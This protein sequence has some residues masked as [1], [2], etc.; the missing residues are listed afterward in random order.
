[1]A[2][3]LDSVARLE[4]WPA[5][6]IEKAGPQL[7]AQYRGQILPLVNLRGALE[8]RQGRRRS[9]GEDV[10]LVPG[11]PRQV[12]VCK[13]NGQLVGLLVERILDIVEDAAEL[14]HP[15]SRAGIVHSTVIQGKVTEV[16]DIPAVLR[17]AGVLS[18]AAHD[19]SLEAGQ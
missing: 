16:L 14:T 1:M 8:E 5:S 19:A 3:R 6:K 15:A 10:S 7:V 17:K 9:A 11:K 13:H 2:M 4:E 12:V 18:A